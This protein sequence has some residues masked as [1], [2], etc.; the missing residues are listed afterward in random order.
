MNCEECQE[1]IAVDADSAEVERHLETCAECREF[2]ARLDQV[3]GLL[4]ETHREA[5]GEAELLQVR[6]RVRERIS[7]GRRR[8]VPVW[9][10]GLAAALALLAV[11]IAQRQER[12]ASDRERPL[13][14]VVRSETVPKPAPT[15]PVKTTSPARARR[16]RHAQPRP[17][18]EP[19]TVKLITDDPNVVIYW[20]IDGKG[21]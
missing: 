13:A 14:A 21:D 8:R 17:P 10:G 1:R 11:W 19:L 3:L 6:E 2:R 5:L 20:I 9:A 16:V 4:Q 7:A 18:A 12:P 15:A